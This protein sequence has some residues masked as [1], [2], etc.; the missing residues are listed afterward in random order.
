MVYLVMVA[1]LSD[2]YSFTVLENTRTIKAAKAQYSAAS[3]K[4]ASIARN[5]KNGK[6]N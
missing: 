5:V 4:V 3:A 2:R 6:A 1:K